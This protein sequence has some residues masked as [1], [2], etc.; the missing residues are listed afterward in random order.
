MDHLTEMAVVHEQLKQSLLLTKQRN[1]CFVKPP[2]LKRA[3]YFVNED[4]SKETQAIRKRLEKSKRIER[5]TY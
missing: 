4:L 5:Y 2:F 3:R 1:T